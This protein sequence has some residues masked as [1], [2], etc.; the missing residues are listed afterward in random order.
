M[1]A[2]GSAVVLLAATQPGLAYLMGRAGLPFTNAAAFREVASLAS[3][4]TTV[5]PT[6]V[7]V[8]TPEKLR[9]LQTPASIG[10]MVNTFE[11]FGSCVK[12]CQCNVFDLSC[13]ETVLAASSGGAVQPVSGA[14]RC[15]AAGHVPPPPVLLLSP[16]AVPTHRSPA[17]VG[18]LRRLGFP[19]AAPVRARAVAQA[20]GSQA[21]GGWA[22]RGQGGGTG[23]PPPGGG[24]PPGGR[25]PPPGGGP[26][27]GMPPPGGRAA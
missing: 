11:Q 21:T 25:G 3:V 16:C 26:P 19:A 2:T 14:A 15:G 23:G 4:C 6:A 13:S 9:S 24:A 5:L 27:G 10:G 12:E 8:S 1:R 17:P 18:Q 7:E 22:G 20:A